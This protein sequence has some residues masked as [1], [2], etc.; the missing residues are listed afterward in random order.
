[1]G[2]DQEEEPFFRSCLQD[3]HRHLLEERVEHADSDREVTRSLLPR[4]LGY[5]TVK[6]K[7][8]PVLRVVVMANV[9]PHAY[10]MKE[11]Y[12][13]K[14]VLSSKRFVSEDQRLQGISVLK[15]RNFMSRSIAV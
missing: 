10:E 1:M 2:V 11:K 3:Y 14:G 6:L 9:F 7:R 13:L 8:E 5:Y 15:D 4:Y 12:D